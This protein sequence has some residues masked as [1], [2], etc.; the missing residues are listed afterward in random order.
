M[1][2]LTDTRLPDFARIL[3][4]INKLLKG[5]GTE[6]VAS[7]AISL[8]ANIILNSAPDRDFDKVDEIADAIND[9]VKVACRIFH[10]TTLN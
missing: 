2:R 9:H 5:Q 1:V 4:K 3:D 6:F 7:I 8:L 10:E